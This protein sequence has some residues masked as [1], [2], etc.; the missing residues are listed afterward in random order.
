MLQARRDHQPIASSFITPLK[1]RAS[2]PTTWQNHLKY[3]WTA[4]SAYLHQHLHKNGRTRTQKSRFEQSAIA[5]R[6]NPGTMQVITHAFQGQTRI[7]LARPSTSPAGK[8]SAYGL[9]NPAEGP[10]AKIDDKS[11]FSPHRSPCRVVC[12][13]AATRFSFLRGR[14][15]IA[16]LALRPFPLLFFCRHMGPSTCPRQ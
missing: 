3:L 12:E 5:P 14:S 11:R 4:N 2:P 7:S 9:H 15:G 6:K 13:K 16:V 10:K 1:T 8:R